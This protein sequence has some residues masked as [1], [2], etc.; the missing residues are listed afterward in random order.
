MDKSLL[1]NQLTNMFM[2]FVQRL[3]Q[4]LYIVQAAF[5][6]IVDVWPPNTGQVWDECAHNC[7]PT[8]EPELPELPGQCLIEMKCIPMCVCPLEK[9]YRRRDGVCH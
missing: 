9:R 8:C 4:S 6:S 1:I 7:Q 2:D 3:S 5:G